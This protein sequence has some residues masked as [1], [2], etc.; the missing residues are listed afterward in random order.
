[1]SLG[2][3]KNNQVSYMNVKPTKNNFD[4]PPKRLTIKKELGR[5]AFGVVLL[6]EADGIIKKRRVDLVALKT[7]KGRSQV[8]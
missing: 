1:M 5:G 7:L 4:F 3:L 2:K 6:A 8:I